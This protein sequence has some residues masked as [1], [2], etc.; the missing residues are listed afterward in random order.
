MTDQGLQGLVDESDDALLGKLLTDTISADHRV[1]VAAKEILD[2][3]GRERQTR[4]AELQA[5]A[6]SRQARAAEQQVQAAQLLT[7]LTKGLVRA[8]WV[9]AWATLGLVVATLVL[10]LNAIL[11]R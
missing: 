11:H 1:Y 5:S 9:L 7:G 6:A 3:R 2:I 8:T 4:A 10:T